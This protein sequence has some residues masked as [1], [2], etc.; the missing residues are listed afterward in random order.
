MM[1]CR[2]LQEKEPAPSTLS[3][4]GISETDMGGIEGNLSEPPRKNTRLQVVSLHNG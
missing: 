3:K 1:K 2:L 4:R